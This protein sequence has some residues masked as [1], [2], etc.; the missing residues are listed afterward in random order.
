MLQQ[1]YP[2][3]LNLNSGIITSKVVVK[4]VVMMIVPITPTICLVIFFSNKPIPIT[5]RKAASARYTKAQLNKM[6]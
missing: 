2:D 3:K 5:I 4:K 6:Y 1:V